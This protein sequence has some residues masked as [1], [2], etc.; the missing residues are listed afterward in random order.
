MSTQA[1]ISIIVTTSEENERF[2]TT[3]LQNTGVLIGVDQKRKLGE[4]LKL[5]ISGNILSLSLLLHVIESNPAAFTGQVTLPDG[6]TVNLDDNGRTRLK[7]A[8]SEAMKQPPQSVRPQD[9]PWWMY[10][11][12]QIGEIITEIAGLVKWYPR[13]VGESQKKVTIA[14]MAVIAGILAVVGGLTYIDKVSGD[15]FIFVVGILLGYIF[16]FLS[17][18]LGLAGSSG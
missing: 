18:F 6:Q 17:K 3:A 11:R 14:F 13:A 10:F 12:P 4:P 16:A 7:N 1:I 8:L 9:A 15:A 2:L 5:T